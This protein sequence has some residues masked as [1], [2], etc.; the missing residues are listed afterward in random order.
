MIIAIAL[1]ICNFTAL[2][3]L[4][5]GEVLSQSL[6]KTASA[7]RYI[8]PWT[9]SAYAYAYDSWSISILPH[10]TDW[11]GYKIDYSTSKV[12]NSQQFYKKIALNSEYFINWF[13]LIHFII[14]SHSL[15]FL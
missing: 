9:S 11:T 10:Y 3:F 5:P 14:I 13:F 2:K 15:T 1:F 6:P 12:F 7:F 4:Q 8:F